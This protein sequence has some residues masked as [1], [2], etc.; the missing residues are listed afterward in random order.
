PGGQARPR[1]GP[2]EAGRRGQGGASA[3]DGRPQDD[4]PAHAPQGAGQAQAGGAQAGGAGDRGGEAEGLTDSLGLRAGDLS[5]GAPRPKRQGAERTV[6]PT[7]DADATASE[8]QVQQ[9]ERGAP[10]PRMTLGE[11]IAHLA[12]LAATGEDRTAG[13]REVARGLFL[14]LASLGWRAQG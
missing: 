8:A 13:E 2:G 5:S 3:D 10:L 11:S 6:M 4:R 14:R 7:R 12:A 9:V 1:P